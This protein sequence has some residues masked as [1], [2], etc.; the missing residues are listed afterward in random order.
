V[1]S[2]VD[3]DVGIDADVRIERS[4]SVA[5]RPHTRGRAFALVGHLRAAVPR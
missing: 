5:L 1:T 2:D 3:I 4:K